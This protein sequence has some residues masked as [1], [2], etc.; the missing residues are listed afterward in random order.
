M[1]ASPPPDIELLIAEMAALAGLLAQV[2]QL[3]RTA[4]IFP[5][6]WEAL[7]EQAMEHPSVCAAVLAAQWDA[8]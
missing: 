3:A 2:V 7:A 6:R 8:P 4:A 1:T 5:S